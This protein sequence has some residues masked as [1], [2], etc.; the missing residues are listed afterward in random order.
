MNQPMR[1]LHLLLLV[2]LHHPLLVVPKQTGEG[3]HHIIIASCFRPYQDQLAILEL[4]CF[5]CNRLKCCVLAYLPFEELH[6]L[7]S[8]HRAIIRCI[9]HLGYDPRHHIIFF[10][11]CRYF[12]FISLTS[13]YSIHKLYLTGVGVL[14]PHT[15]KILLTFLVDHFSFFFFQTLHIFYQIQTTSVFH[16]H[17]QLSSC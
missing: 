11:S 5:L 10:L 4:H 8:I 7:D 15:R 1:P 13:S 14:M 17:G 2:V 3:L 16:I 6:I 12:D 9:L